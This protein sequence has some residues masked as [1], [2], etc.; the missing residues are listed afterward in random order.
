M[1]IGRVGR[2]HGHWAQVVLRGA[3]DRMGAGLVRPVHREGDGEKEGD[4]VVR[5][6]GARPVVVRGDGELRLQGAVLPLA[7]L[8]LLTKK[9]KPEGKALAS[10]KAPA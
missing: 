10:P 8:H 9:K 2:G 5:E 3:G 1:E 6:E 7:S 4:V